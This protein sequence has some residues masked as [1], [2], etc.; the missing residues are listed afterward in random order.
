[1]YCTALL[2]FIWLIGEENSEPNDQL[3]C[4][5]SLFHSMY[6]QLV[7]TINQVNISIFICL[8]EIMMHLMG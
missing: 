1:M 6:V 2:G 7:L 8:F 5:H 4:G 3:Y